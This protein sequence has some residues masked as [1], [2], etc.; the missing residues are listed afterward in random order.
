MFVIASFAV[1]GL[2]NWI[3]VA[4]GAVVGG[5]IGFVALPAVG[6]AIGVGAAGPVAGGAFAAL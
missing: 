3:G 2:A 4:A 6:L 5:A 1:C